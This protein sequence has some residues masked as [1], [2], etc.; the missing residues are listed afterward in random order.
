MRVTEKLEFYADDNFTPLGYIDMDGLDIK[1]VKDWNEDAIK[2]EAKLESKLSKHKSPQ[3]EKKL[4][5]SL[6]KESRSNKK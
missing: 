5:K 2:E 3:E 4:S 6:R 1:G